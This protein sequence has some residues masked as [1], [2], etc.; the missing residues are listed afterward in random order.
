MLLAGHEP[1]DQVSGPKLDRWPL[2]YGDST[3]R[4]KNELSSC[5]IYNR[6]PRLETNRPKPFIVRIK[7]PPLCWKPNCSTFRRERRVSFEAIMEILNAAAREDDFD[8]VLVAELVT[9]RDGERRLQRLFSRLRSQPQLRNRFLME[10]AAIE[11]RAE[12]LD[13]VL[14][15]LEF[16]DASAAL[17]HPTFTPAA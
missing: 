13:A 3:C 2:R 9:L 11:Q 6:I 4:L 17:A 15:P 12:R 8:A 5:E 14:N 1:S 10:L 7:N 16:F